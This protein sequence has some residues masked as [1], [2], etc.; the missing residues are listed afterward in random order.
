MNILERN[1]PEGVATFLARMATYSEDAITQAVTREGVT[2]AEARKITQ[3][4]L[5]A[6]RVR[7]TKQE[8]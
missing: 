1:N 4:A 2:E 5:E 3:D 7:R 8:V 6:E